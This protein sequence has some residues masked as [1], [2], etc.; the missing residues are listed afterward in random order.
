MQRQNKRR[1]TKK[2]E[3]PTK[4]I[5]TAD[6][7]D[8]CAQLHKKQK[9]AI[10]DIINGK[11]KENNNNK[12]LV[13][14]CVQTTE[15]IRSLHKNNQLCIE[16]F[17]NKQ[18]NHFEQSLKD[19][20]LL[21]SP[22]NS[23]N[24]SCFA[25]NNKS[26]FCELRPDYHISTTHNFWYKSIQSCKMQCC[27]RDTKDAGINMFFTSHNQAE[28]R[29][30]NRSN[31]ELDTQWHKNIIKF[32]NKKFLDIHTSNEREAKQTE[33]KTTTPCINIGFI[34][35]IQLSSQ[36][37]GYYILIT[38]NGS[39]INDRI[40]NICKK[41][42]KYCLLLKGIH[43]IPVFGSD[44]I[45][46]KDVTDFDTKAYHAEGQ[47]ALII[48]QLNKAHSY[49]P[50]ITAAKYDGCILSGHLKK[51]FDDLNKPKNNI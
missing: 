20:G 45:A 25:I 2:I 29:L 4:T 21:Y 48:K 27:R 30:Y 33:T 44:F 14:R 35:V 51:T 43:T 31:N 8:E 18:A 36:K 32:F 7:D 49:K 42:N 22:N 37:Y 12:K 38:A 1:N 41:L 10:E 46:Q 6:S 13:K 5:A 34:P 28:H 23:D 39:N 3:L 24:L 50:N 17:I 16:A 15:G 9:K 19:A 47:L 26:T 40:N 11:D